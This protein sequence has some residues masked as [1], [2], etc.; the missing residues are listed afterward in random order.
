MPANYMEL[1]FESKTICWI[2]FRMGVVSRRAQ[3]ERLHGRGVRESAGGCE[4]GFPKDWKTAMEFRS[5]EICRRTGGVQLNNGDVFGLGAFLASRY[6]E[7]D[8]LSFLQ[9]AAAFAVDCRE[10]NEYIL[11]AVAGNEA[12]AFFIVEPFYNAGL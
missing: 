8:I 1:V 11:S 3:K 4:E 6:F 2:S 7:G 12:E 5:L 10:M 9:A